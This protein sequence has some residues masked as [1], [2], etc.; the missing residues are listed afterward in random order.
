M[1]RAYFNGHN[2]FKFLSILRYNGPQL[3]C[4]HT[5]LKWVLSTSMYHLDLNQNIHDPVQQDSVI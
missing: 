1:Y 5:T 2:Y 3:M 4:K